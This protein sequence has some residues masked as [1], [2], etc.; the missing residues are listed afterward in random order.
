VHLVIDAADPARLARFW[1][2]ALGWE[3]ADETPDEVDVWPDGYTYP[4]PVALPLV[5]VPVPEPKT[6][7][8]RVH[9]DLATESA[10]HQAAEVERL[11]VLGAVRADVGQGDVPWVVLADP[12]GNEFCVLDPRPAYRDTGPVA[13]VVADCADP[14]AVAGFWEL[15]TGWV[16]ADSTQNG[17][18]FRSPRSVGPYLELLPSSDPKRVKN[19]VHLDVRPQAGENQAEAVKALLD[20][21]AVPADVGQGD[22]NWVVLADPEGSEFC[23]LRPR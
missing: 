9:L 19:R 4:D 13:A 20:A 11:L 16:R 22:V 3:V 15:A 23:V 8:N 1:A 10:A 18:S 17:V 21:G 6:G 12:E 7:K 5:F 14:A 2:A